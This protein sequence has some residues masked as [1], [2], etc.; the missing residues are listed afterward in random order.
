V[1]R[2]TTVTADV[3]VCANFAADT[4]RV[5]FDSRG[6]SVVASVTVGYG[7]TVATPTAPIRPGYT[8]DGWFV[9]TCPEVRWAFSTSVTAD[10]ALWAK[11]IRNQTISFDSNG[12]TAVAAIS[13]ARG[14]I[15]ATPT[16]PAKA[17][18][19]FVGW[20]TTSR[21]KIPYIFTTMPDA[22]I[23]LYAKWAVGTCT[24]TFDGNGAPSSSAAVTV[25]CGATLGASMPK[26]PTRTGYVFS[27]WNT[28]PDGTGASFG[29]A[30]PVPNDITVYA[31]W[32]PRTLTVTFRT[33]GCGGTETTW[34]TR[35]VNYGSTATTP[36]AP[37]RTGYALDGWYT[38]ARPAVR[39]D[40]STPIT[41]DLVLYARWAESHTISFDC[42]GGTRVSPIC[43]AWGSAVATPPAPTRNGYVFAGWYTTSRLETPY[44]FTTMPNEDITLHAKWVRGHS[45]CDRNPKGHSPRKDDHAAKPASAKVSEETSRTVP[46]AGVSPA[47]DHPAAA[48]HESGASP[49]AHPSVSDSSDAGAS[50]EPPAPAGSS[51]ARS[52]A[53]AGP[54]EDSIESAE[55]VTPGA[56]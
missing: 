41:S 28:R 4:L 48:A 39:W 38:G 9:A 42:D 3:R 5:T 17:G 26:D 47:S 44:V 36:T 24:V 7:S 30:T 20:Y 25:A 49:G 10:L 19:V 21:L 29:S 14:S 15:V 18:C 1:R 6:G 52:A 34:C 16:A 27:R 50:D 13:Q 54:S 55:P 8:F 43:Q 35:T 45:G 11:W 31:V 23:T 56:P 32:T 12:G 53:S 40:F 33:A 51:T 22:D 2:D 37:V 46:T